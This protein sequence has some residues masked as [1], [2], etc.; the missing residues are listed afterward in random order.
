MHS[1][2][3]A[4][5]QPHRKFDLDLPLYT[6]TFWPVGVA[7]DTHLGHLAYGK[8]PI[9]SPDRM[10]QPSEIQYAFSKTED[11]TGS[12]KSAVGHFMS[13]HVQPL[14]QLCPGN[15]ATNDKGFNAS[16]QPQRRGWSTV[17]LASS[18]R[19]SG[20]TYNSADIPRNG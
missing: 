18:S 6:G 20:Y 12:K 11:G 5:W 10:L 7:L 4:L 17:A 15:R 1:S 9:A 3:R 19:G 16:R 8:Q 2:N 14:G 13:W